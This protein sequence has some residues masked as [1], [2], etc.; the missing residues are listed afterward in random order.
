MSANTLIDQMFSAGAHFGLGRSRRHPTVAPFIFGT[1][2]RTDIFDLE[3]TEK[4]LEAAKAFVTALGKEGKTI[5]FVGG[6]K[7]ASA[8]VKT[9]AMSL[10]MPYVEGRWIGGTLTNFGN[11]RKRIERY[12]KLISDREKGELA[13]Y[14]KRERML[15][16]REIAKLERMFLGIVS[17]KKMPE[18]LF[19]IDPRKEQN[20]IGEAGHAKIPVMALASSDCNISEVKFPIVGNDAAKASIQFFLSEIAAAYQAGKKEAK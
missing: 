10:N 13:K 15:I 18:L 4:T 17:L 3:K 6:K 9:A 2:N 12:E 19:L 8:L 20:A 11:I 7:E 1:K 5:L 14:T 16:D